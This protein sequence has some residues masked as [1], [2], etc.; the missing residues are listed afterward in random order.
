VE[1]PDDP[2]GPGEAVT[3][4]LARLAARLRHAWRAERGALRF[5]TAPV[6][7]DPVEAELARLDLLAG[8]RVDPDPEIDKLAERALALDARCASLRA[9]RPE[10]PLFR[11]WRRAGLDPVGQDLLLLSLA[12][13]VE[14]GFGRAFGLLG[15]HRRPDVATAIRLLSP[16]DPSGAAIRRALAPG[17][18]LVRLGLVELRDPDRAGGLGAELVAPAPVVAAALGLPID[19]AALA[20]VA[21]LA[22]PP[23]DR[24]PVAEALRDRLAVLLGQPGALPI[25]EG[26]ALYERRAVARAAAAAAGRRLVEVDL[27]QERSAADVAGALRLAW[28]HDAAMVLELPPP[29]PTGTPPPP[30]LV[31]A[32]AALLARAAGPLL[33]SRHEGGPSPAL[34]TDRDLALLPVPLGDLTIRARLWRG[35]LGEALGGLDADQLARSYALS[36]GDIEQ[37]ARAARLRLEARGGGALTLPDLVDAIDLLH[38]GRLGRVGRR[39]RQRVVLAD[40]VLPGDA[41]E[42]LEELEATVRLRTQVLDDW[43]FGTLSRGRGVSALF[44]GEPGTGKTMAASAIATAC[45]LALYQIDTAQVVSKWIGE[46]EKNLAEVFRAAES[47]HALLLFD[48]ADAVFGK[49][50][51]VKGSTDRYAN[52][53]TNFLLTQLET[54]NGVS[55]LTTNRDSAMDAAFMRRLS[56]RVLFPMPEVEE[57]EALWARCLAV[58]D[59]ALARE[60][61]VAM[62]ARRLVMSGGYIRN[63]VLRGAYLAAQAG[64]PITTDLLRHA[65]ELVLRD[66]GKV[67]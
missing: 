39:L 55:I 10:L 28:L 1:R 17:A 57:R 4:E 7:G 36:G 47:N 42:T 58:H 63:A 21:A 20:G 16:D 53:Q 22:G 48:E 52:L 12:S 11:L 25:L 43:R 44:Y 6:G 65:A 19:D 15:G 37:A 35:G 14:G 24:L 27:S 26:P 29:D 51:E 9:G 30:G 50:T 49:R 54:F 41:R 67:V 8:R 45:G 32:A 56:F 3:L 60:V 2:T 23:P 46:T 18:P 40:L 61:D 5:V 64:A 31:G 34:P 38:A 33:L 62:L 66:A 13:E 59:P